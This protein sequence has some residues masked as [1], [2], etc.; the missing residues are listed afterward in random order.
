MIDPEVKKYVDDSID[1]ADRF[2]T[3]KFGDTPTDAQ[4]LTPKKYVDGQITSIISSFNGTVSTIGTGIPTVFGDGS[5]GAIVFDGTTSFSYAS[6]VSS[7]VYSQLRDI[8]ATT[9]TINNGVTLKP[10]QWRAF[11]SS[12]LQIN[13]ASVTSKGA[14]AVLDIGG[15]SIVGGYFPSVLAG[16]NGNGGGG[17][18]GGAGQGTVGGNGNI[19]FMTSHSF[20]VNGVATRTIVSVLGGAADAFVGGAG[21]NQGLGGS[22]LGYVTR[23]IPIWGTQY[24]LD[25]NNDGT[26]SKMT[27]S[28]GSGGAPGGGSG[29]RA[30]TNQPAGAGGSGGGAGG[31]GGIVA[32]YAKSIV[33]TVGSVIDVQ[34]GVGGTGSNGQTPSIVASGQAG[35]GAG[36]AGGSG[37]QGGYVVLVYNT[38]VNSGSILTAGGGPGSSGTGAAGIQGGGTGGDGLTGFSGNAGSVMSFKITN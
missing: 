10:R 21:G 26:L 2:S 32:L 11:A 24:F 15:V 33:L 19:G 28:A 22:V 1:E 9:L 30:N 14:N 35:G 7:S 12:V 36:G 38:I 37:G 23:P 4:Q 25:V 6:I 8:Y 34:G 20:G 18:P 27:G 31:N 5:D 29:A 17:S 3:A 13:N 16:S